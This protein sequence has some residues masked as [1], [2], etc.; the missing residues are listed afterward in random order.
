MKRSED[1]QKQIN[2]LKKQEKNFFENIFFKDKNIEFILTEDEFCSWDASDSK[3]SYELKIRDFGFKFFKEDYGC[4]PMIEIQKYNSL[5]KEYKNSGK[6]PILVFAF[7]DI[8]SKE[9]NGYMFW[10]LL[11]Y[12]NEKLTEKTVK[13]LKSEVQPELGYIMKPCYFFE[14][15][16]FQSNSK[17]YINL[18]K[19][20]NT[21]KEPVEDEFDLL[22]EYWEKREKNN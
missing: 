4:R 6:K 18:I 8:V 5:I 21:Y 11:N 2:N 3:F 7:T 1:T 19:E 9:I 13:C 17:K 14:D 20:E 15:K 22:I 12:P 16:H 10:N